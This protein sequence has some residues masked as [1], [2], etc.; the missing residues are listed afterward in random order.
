MNVLLRH[1]PIICI[2]SLGIPARCIAIAAPDRIEWVPTLSAL[3]PSRSS[4][5]NFVAVLRCPS[6]IFEE[7]FRGLSAF[8]VANAFIVTV[9]GAARS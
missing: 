7:M 6:I 9:G 4:P 1:R 8:V 3:R 5:A 2:V